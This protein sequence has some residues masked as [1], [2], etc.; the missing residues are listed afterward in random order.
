VRLESLT[1]ILDVSDL[2]ASLEWFEALG[3]ER[4]FAWGADGPGSADADFA[5]VEAGDAEIFLCLDNQGARGAWMSWFVSSHAELDAVYARARELGYE[6]SREP[7][8]EPWG[9]REFHLRHPD[10]HTF[11]VSCQGG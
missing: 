10:G 3:W 11:R 4:G 1:P 9:V 5:S 8:D 2:G 6:I 7:A